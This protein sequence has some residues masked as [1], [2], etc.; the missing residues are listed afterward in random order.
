MQIFKKKNRFLLLSHIILILLSIAIIVP[1]WILF[2]ASF[3]DESWAVNHGFGLIP[4]EWSTLAYQY[5]LSRWE[6][7]GKSL[8]DY[9]LRNV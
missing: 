7:F 2:A 4:G 6:T 9:D 8:S 3:T 1:F 5:V